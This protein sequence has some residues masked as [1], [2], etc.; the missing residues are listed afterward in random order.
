MPCSRLF[1]SPCHTQPGYMSHTT[2]AYHLNGVGSVPG[3]TLR[4]KP[5]D[6]LSL[7]LTNNLEDTGADMPEHYNDNTF[8]SKPPP[9]T[10][11]FGWDY[12]AARAH[13]LPASIP[14]CSEFS[15]EKKIHQPVTFTF[16]RSQHN[17]PAH[18]RRAPGPA[19]ERPLPPHPPGQWVLHLRLHHPRRPPAG[20]ILVRKTERRTYERPSQQNNANMKDSLKTG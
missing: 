7:T 12:T 8:H 3:P 11:L 2:R 17:E 9:L 18:L 4:V 16:R 20:A 6:V 14:P 5:G 1:C 10:H 15:F 13:A 19:G